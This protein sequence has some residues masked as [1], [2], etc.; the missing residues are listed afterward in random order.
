MHRWP[1]KAF[2]SLAKSIHSSPRSS[3]PAAS[4]AFIRHRRRER[5]RR[6]SVCPAR[7]CTR[8]RFQMARKGERDSLRSRGK[9]TERVACRS[10]EQMSCS[11]T[12][13]LRRHRGDRKD[14]G[15]P[16]CRLA[17]SLARRLS[18][19]VTVSVPRARRSIARLLSLAFLFAAGALSSRAQVSRN[20][21]C[22]ATL[23]SGLTNDAT[24]T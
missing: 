17:C 23:D 24:Y 10:P 19:I 9:W 20:A 13:H 21:R 12:R 11:P 5:D 7:D 16:G 4:N 14:L 22:C 3:L 1:A 6:F 15:I 2:R 8:R 18:G